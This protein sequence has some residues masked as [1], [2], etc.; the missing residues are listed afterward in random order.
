MNANDRYEELKA[1]AQARLAA[2]AA[3]VPVKKRHRKGRI[4]IT[5]VVAVGIILVVGIV[6]AVNGGSSSSPYSRGMAWEA[7]QEHAGAVVNFGAVDPNEGGLQDWCQ[8][9]QPADMPGSWTS[10]CVQGY[11]NLHPGDIPGT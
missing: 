8:T 6:L 5:A 9:N 4:F 1:E 2:Q 11:L 7:S 3:A 10:G